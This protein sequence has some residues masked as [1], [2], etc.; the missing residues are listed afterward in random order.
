M[1]LPELKKLMKDN[2]IKGVNYVNKNEI[3]QRLIEY[4]VLPED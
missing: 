4:K 2:N 1:K 3:I